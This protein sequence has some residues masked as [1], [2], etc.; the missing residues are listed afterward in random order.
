MVASNPMGLSEHIHA[1]SL[2]RSHDER[3]VLD[4][5]GKNVI[6]VPRRRRDGHG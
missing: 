4:P 5:Y 3:E 6:A 1:A 2:P